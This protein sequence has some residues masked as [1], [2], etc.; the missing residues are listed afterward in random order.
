M[1]QGDGIGP[2]GRNQPLLRLCG[3]IQE[4]RHHVAVGVQGQGHLR[5]AEELGVDLGMLPRSQEQGRRRVPK[6]AGTHS[7]QPGHFEGLLLNHR[8]I[9]DA[10]APHSPPGPFGGALSEGANLP[11]GGRSR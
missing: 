10:G 7:G 8:T 6:V 4:A 11:A 2:G 9:V 5:V 1:T 3:L